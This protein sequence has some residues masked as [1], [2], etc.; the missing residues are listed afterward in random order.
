MADGKGTPADGVDTSSTLPAGVIGAPPTIPGTMQLPRGQEI[1]APPEMPEDARYAVQSEIARGGMGRVVE[2]T[3]TVL[4]RTVAVKEALSLDPDA[5]RR[6]Q[7]ETRITAR[8]EHPSIVPVH[9]AG[10]ASNGSPFYVMRKVGGRPLEELVARA[11]ELPARLALVP[12]VVA[13]ANAIAHAH[14]RGIVHRD[15]KPSNILAGDLGE[16]IVI[17]WGLAKGIDEADDTHAPVQRVLDD[18]DDDTIKTRAGIVFGTPGFMAPEQLRGNP[19]DERCDVYALGAT[20]YH[21]LARRPPHYS[22]NAADMMHAAVAG[23]PTPLREIVPGVPA[24]LATIVDKALAHDNTARYQNAKGLAEDLQRFLAGQLVASHYYTPRER[25]LRFLHQYRAAVGVAAASVVA[26]LLV[27]SIMFMKVRNERDRADE[28]A[29]VA[30]AQKREAEAQ[31]EKAIRNSRE[32]VLANARHL[33]TSDPTRAAAL[34]RPLLDTELW[35]EAR[36]VIAAARVNGIAFALSASPHTT[37]LELSRDGQRALAAG[38]DGIVR[39]YDLAKREAKIVADMKGTVRARYADGE[40]KIV[41]FEG[42]RLTVLDVESGGKRDVTTPTPVARLEV[43]GPI[44]FWVDPAGAVWKL[45]LA[46]G[47]PQQIVIGEAV[48]YAVPSPDDRWIALGGVKHLLLIDRSAPSSPPEEITDGDVHT[49]TWSGDSLHLVALIDDMLIDVVTDPA[50]QIF[51]RVTVGERFSVAY[52][53][54][55]IFSAGPTGVGLVT[56]D[57]TKI[58]SSGPEHTLGVFEARDRVVVS[59]KPQGQII[60][61]SDYGDHVLPCPTTISSVATSAR[62]PWIVA[63]TDNKLLVWDL[64][65]VEPRAITALPPSSAKFVSGDALIATVDGAPAQWIDLRSRKSTPLGDDMQG[66][67]ALAASPDG[68]VAVAID[69]T[70]KAW[71]VAGLGQ[72]QA[73]DG[74]VTAATF[75]DNI[76]LVVAGDGG[77]RLEDQQKH[78]KLALYAHSA[79]ARALVSVPNNGGWVAAAFEDGVVWRKHLRDG[80]ASELKS[81]ASRIALGA[82]GTVFIGDAGEVR[83]WRPDGR[84]DTLAKGLKTVTEV[85]LLDTSLLV[86]TDDAN[87]YELDIKLPSAPVAQP[88]V[89]SAVYAPRGGLVAGL[90]PTGGVEVFDPATKQGWPLTIPTKGQAPYSFVEIAPDGTRVLAMTASTLLVWTLDLPASAEATRAWLDKLTNA[91]ADSPSEPL[92][93]R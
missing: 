85:A 86:L 56:K 39:V 87:A 8:L 35:R 47:A 81:S 25:V 29:T 72:P 60:V 54:G 20:L 41:L 73:L 55:R 49:L 7:R 28:Q 16:T 61:L 32:L 9:D 66:L 78:T 40:R 51:H 45:D 23:P 15:I 2:A 3:D 1:G 24:E 26:I 12:H 67:V 84:V 19:V 74:E 75:L 83:A 90:S 30:V 76:Q 50:P 68:A 52:S 17:D 10:V 69:L 36:D 59:A 27:A 92:T 5:L 44:A 70:R 6:F 82:D 53:N 63:A 93:W 34:V 31:R 21:L 88:I 43:A 13:A 42:N 37:S 38:D 71:L 22:K 64:D 48:K 46:G 57:A 14:S 4:G 11:S 33:A 89:H 79:A 58:R 80:A 62:G 18:S 65:A 91:T 77:V